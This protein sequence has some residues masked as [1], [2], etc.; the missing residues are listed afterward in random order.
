MAN[1]FPQH[2]DDQFINDLVRKSQEQAER[3]LNGQGNTAAQ[4]PQ[5]QEIV[6]HS[7][8][9]AMVEIFSNPRIMSHLARSLKELEQQG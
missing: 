1:A 4:T 2:T 3:L 6:Y 8:H 9:R 7:V 5:L